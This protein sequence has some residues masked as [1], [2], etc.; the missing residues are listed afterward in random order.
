MTR[1]QAIR[2]LVLLFTG[3][4]PP[5]TIRKHSLR[6]LDDE[7]HFEMQSWLANN[8][9]LPWLSGVG[10]IEAI[11]ALIDASEEVDIQGFKEAEKFYP[12]KSRT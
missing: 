4:E 6:K 7:Q 9:R 3:K 10:T 12:T 1:T 11:D 8:V 5:F 2:D